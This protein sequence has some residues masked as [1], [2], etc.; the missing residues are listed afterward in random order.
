MT[1]NTT[2]A[3]LDAVDLIRGVGAGQCAGGSRPLCAN[4]ARHFLVRWR[5]RRCGP[6]VL[7]DRLLVP[8]AAGCRRRRCSGKNDTGS[9]RKREIYAQNCF[10]CCSSASCR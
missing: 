7:L 10:G 9:V 4:A 8:G 3:V 5:L 1:G 6:V 2:Q